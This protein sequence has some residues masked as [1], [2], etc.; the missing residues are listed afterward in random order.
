MITCKNCNHAYEGKFCPECGQKAKT[1]RITM[2]QVLK[3]IRSHFINFD[4]GFLYTIKEL[5]THPG[6]S[7]REYL[8]GKRVRHIKPLKFMFWATAISFLLSHYIGFQ[9]RLLQ[10]IQENQVDKPQSQQF[11]RKITD[12][13]MGYPSLLILSILPGIALCSWLFFRKKRYNYA[14][15][16]TINAF[17]LGEITLLSV[18]INI[19]YLLWKDISLDQVAIIGTMQWL[20]WATYFGWAYGQLFNQEKKWVAW[21]K[22]IAVLFLGYVVLII[23]ISIA[24]GIV[25]SLFKPQVEQWLS[26]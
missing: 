23:L 5:A 26:N 15:H 8:E 11:G 4:Q 16:F 21:I 25:L 10:K 1:G 6:H 17:L 22:G 14:E 7:I 3:D 20:F 12:L 19:L 24:A 9:E 18:I 2:R 13:I